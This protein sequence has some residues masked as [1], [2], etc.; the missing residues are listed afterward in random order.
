MNPGKGYQQTTLVG[1]NDLIS[2]FSDRAAT[3]KLFAKHKPTHVIHLA[4]MVGGLFKNLKYNL[5]FYVS[6]ITP[7]R[8]QSKILLT[9]NERSKIARVRTPLK[10]HKLLSTGMGPPSR[11]N[12][13]QGV[14]TALC[15][16]R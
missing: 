7:V 8:R 12:W 9:I 6:T 5:D 15:E 10:N 16:I 2:C 4:A 3:E 13:T 1:K 11:S 14:S